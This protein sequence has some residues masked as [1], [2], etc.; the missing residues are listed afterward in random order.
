MAMGPRSE[1]KVVIDGVLGLTTRVSE[2]QVLETGPVLLA[3]PL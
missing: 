1:S 2:V 3:S